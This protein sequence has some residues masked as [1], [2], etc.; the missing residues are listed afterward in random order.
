[1]GRKRVYTGGNSF[2]GLHNHHV[3]SGKPPDKAETFLMAKKT[4]KTN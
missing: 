4:T 2:L 1:M 3:C